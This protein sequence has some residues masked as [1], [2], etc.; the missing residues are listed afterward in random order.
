MLHRQT[1][2]RRIA[3]SAPN[4]AAGSYDALVSLREPKHAKFMEAVT[5]NEMTTLKARPMIAVTRNLAY[6]NR[7]W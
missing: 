6:H 2:K 1:T 4:A 3:R 7:E 5:T